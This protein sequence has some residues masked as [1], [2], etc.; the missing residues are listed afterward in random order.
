M[1]SN[2]RCFPGEDV[3]AT[4]LIYMHPILSADVLLS[5]QIIRQA[6]TFGGDFIRYS[7][8]PRES[9]APN[10]I[11]KHKIQ[12]QPFST[13]QN[14]QTLIKTSPS[15]LLITNIVT[16]DF[17]NDLGKVAGMAAPS[18]GGFACFLY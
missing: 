15:F 5:R 2:L 16:D 8:R 6:W 10:M 17:V 1:F 13:H 14:N 11:P 3:D 9:F 18:F 7:R 4:V 12:N